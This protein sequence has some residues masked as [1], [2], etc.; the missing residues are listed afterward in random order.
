MNDQSDAELLR[1]YALEGADSAFA[2]LVNRHVDLVYSVALR[3]GR[4][5]HLAQDVCQ[6]VFIA[7]AKCAQRLAHR[8]V[9]SGWLHRTTTNIAAQAVRTEVRRLCPSALPAS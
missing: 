9:L 7:L 8:E 5:P 6:G 1:R 3:S 4:D 2:E